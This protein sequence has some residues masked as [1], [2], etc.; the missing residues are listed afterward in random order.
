MTAFVEKFALEFATTLAVGAVTA[1]L[2]G[3]STTGE[4]AGRRRRSSAAPRRVMRDPIE[5]SIRGVAQ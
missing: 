3:V 4:P 1:F 5:V 2:V